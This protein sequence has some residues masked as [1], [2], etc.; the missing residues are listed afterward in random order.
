MVQGVKKP[1]LLQSLDC[2]EDRALAEEFMDEEDH[3]GGT[4]D[5]DVFT[6]HFNSSKKENLP[7]VP[8]G[9]MKRI[10]IRPDIIEQAVGHPDQGAIGSWRHPPSYFNDNDANPKPTYVYITNR[11]GFAVLLP[12]GKRIAMKRV[13]VTTTVGEIINKAIKQAGLDV[14][15][16]NK[17]LL[18]HKG[19]PM[20]SKDAQMVSFGIK[21]GDVLVLVVMMPVIVHTPKGGTKRF[22]VKDTMPFRQLLRKIGKMVDLPV[23]DLSITVR[24][25]PT[26]KGATIVWHLGAAKPIV[27]KAGART[28]TL[29]LQLPSAKKTQAATDEGHSVS[30][31]PS[32]AHPAKVRSRATASDPE[33]DGRRC[34]CTD[35]T[36]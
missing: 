3:P 12:S 32:A 18:Y 19:K 24:G 15:K 16:H 11:L 17:V 2:K 4:F 6:Y 31:I 33:E 36:Q 10:A 28:I 34:W 26:P 21:D 23:K 30:P 5:E 13:A 20:R 27:I 29:T 22:T 9:L 25:K 8:P 1:C 35:A 7:T 14:G